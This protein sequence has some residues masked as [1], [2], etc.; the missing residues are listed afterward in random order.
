MEKRLGQE[1]IEFNG[2]NHHVR[3]LCHVINLAVQKFINYVS[4][5]EAEE[6][7]IEKS[8]VLKAKKKKRRVSVRKKQNTRTNP[9]KNT[10]CNNND[11]EDKEISIEKLRK[12][13]N[14]IRSSTVRFNIYKKICVERD[15]SS[16]ILNVDTPT[17][18]SS[19]FEMV[20]SSINHKKE[21]KLFCVG[22]FEHLNLSSAEWKRLKSLCTILETFAMHTTFFE[23]SSYPT[24]YLSLPSFNKLFDVL[25]DPQ[26]KNMFP[27]SSKESFK[28]LKKYYIISDL[29]NAHIVSAII[30]PS[31]KMTY[32]KA[33]EHM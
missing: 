6:D 25:E 5:I 28:K 32:F 13:I 26:V 4:V 9:S 31:L 22:E 14:T 17:R 21:I 24:I 8:N 20:K 19:T 23:G 12:I 1:G 3:C 33:E 16:L 15:C 7:Q 2:D 10:E 30:S 27:K 29:T 18:W 11:Q